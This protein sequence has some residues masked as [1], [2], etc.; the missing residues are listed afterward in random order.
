MK[1]NCNVNL[2]RIVDWLYSMLVFI[3]L[4]PFFSWKWTIIPVSTISICFFIFIFD[5]IFI[6]KFKIDKNR[7]L[8]LS[9]I[10]SIL[11]LF[12][13]YPGGK[14]PWFNYYSMFLTLFLVLPI[15]RLIEIAKNFRKIFILSLI[16]GLIIYLLLVLGFDLPYTIL[17]AHNV[18]KDSLGIYYRDYGGT[19]AL[20]HLIITTGTST[21][22]RFSGMLDEPGLLGTICA[23]LLLADRINLKRISNVILL[24]SGIVSI[25]LAFYLLILLGVILQ[26]KRRITSLFVVFILG[27]S[28][29]YS[30]VYDN[31]L[32]KRLDT[33]GTGMILKDN[34]VSDCFQSY[35]DNFT[36]SDDIS[37]MLGNGNN[38]HLDTNC[39]VSSYKM[40]VYDYGYLGFFILVI[41]QVLQ[42][43]IPFFRSDFIRFTKFSFV[44]L[45]LF[46]LSYYQ[47]PVFFNLAFSMVL[48]YSYSVF[49]DTFKIKNKN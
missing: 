43:V 19:V 4:W 12:L 48:F 28:V 9:F 49:L 1:G 11:A 5:F 31:F 21:I 15:D 13:L 30:P 25:S 2:T 32:K 36:K 17:D 44:F 29:Y 7:F 47:R 39:D 10:V 38:A 22:I 14:P 3:S 6:N 18:L 34:R 46:S 45:C 33:D 27:V 16:P 37:L 42:Y 8:I 20:S 40:Y 24:V 41:L 26:G 35:Y 23:L